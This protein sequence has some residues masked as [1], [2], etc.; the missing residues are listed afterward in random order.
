[1]KQFF[2]YSALLLV[3]GAMVARAAQDTTLSQRQVR[4]PRQLETVLEANAT[5]A[6]T[7]MAAT[8]SAAATVTVTGADLASAGTGTVTIQLVDAA[9]ES[10]AEEALV[11]TWIGTADDFGVDALTDY[12]VSTGTQKE[13]VTANG[14]YLAISDTNGVVVMAIDNGGAATNY[15]WVAIGGRIVASG[16]IVLTAP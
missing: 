1:M 6:E 14:E 2:F 4:D 8:E 13:E 5:D 11:R 10:L 3:A 16:A 15:A 12:S 7:R 9:G